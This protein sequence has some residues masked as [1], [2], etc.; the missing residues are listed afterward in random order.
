M[1]IV[2]NAREWLLLQQLQS[3]VEGVPEEV[4]AEASR[5]LGLS[6]ERA[7]A[8]ESLWLA[9]HAGESVRLAREAVEL[10]REAIGDANE[11]LP[12]ASRDIER[13]RQLRDLH[14]RLLRE[15]EPLMLGPHAVIRRRRVRVALAALSLVMLCFLLVAAMR[16][17]NRVRVVASAQYGEHYTALEAID[18]DQQTEWLLPD[19]TAGFVDVHI[20]PRRRI[21][22][23]KLMNARNIPFDDRATRDVSVEAL[24]GNH[25]VKNGAA[26]FEGPS[27]EA[28]WRTIEVGTTV[29]RLRVHVR[30]WHAAGGG[31]AEIVVE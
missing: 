29:D 10:A 26:S 14:A 11:S 22:R 6:R 13:Y 12:A 8:A 31:F 5:L 3:R 30:S 19:H 20:V 24:D 4:R 27:R 23:V 18:G 17:R 1:S 25:V 16:L 28:V 15:H 2:T 21:A 7:A 9:G